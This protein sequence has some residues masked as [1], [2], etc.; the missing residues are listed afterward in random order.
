VRKP[1]VS[2]ANARRHRSGENDANTSR[3]VYVSRF[4]TFQRPNTLKCLLFV[5][6]D[7]TWG[8]QFRKESVSVE[9]ASGSAPATGPLRNRGSASKDAHKRP[10]GCGLAVR[11]KRFQGSDASVSVG[12]AFLH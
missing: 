2:R 1:L 5:P 4:G 10:K 3:S 11:E 12:E 8:R 6:S 7:P 9:A